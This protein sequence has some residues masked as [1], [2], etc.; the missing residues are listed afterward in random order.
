MQFEP[1]LFTA[2]PLPS[3]GPEPRLTADLPDELAAI[4]EQLQDDSARLAERYP[5]PRPRARSRRWAWAAAVAAASFTTG[6]GAA[7]WWTSRSSAR[8]LATDA[9]T[10]AVAS[11]TALADGRPLASPLKVVRSEEPSLEASRTQATDSLVGAGPRTLPRPSRL[12][13]RDEA[14]LLR[15]QVAAFELVIER[16]QSELR[17]RADQ[18]SQ[19]DAVVA[20]LRREIEELRQRLDEP[21]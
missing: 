13:M 12:P 20:E 1:R 19:T 9:K 2:E 16:L 11:A 18:Q 17:E 7:A 10:E 3:A 14:A 21:R 8:Q 4:A 5:P 6:V 15:R